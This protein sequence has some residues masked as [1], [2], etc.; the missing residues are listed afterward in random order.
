ML[1]TLRRFPAVAA[2]LALCLVVGPSASALCAHGGEAHEAAPTHEGGVAPCHE[3]METPAAPADDSHGDECASACCLRAVETPTLTP[4]PPVP[5]VV[6][7]LVAS[8][9]TDRPAPP[10]VGGVERATRPPP[11]RLYLE[12]G[13]IRV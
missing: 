5:A 13:R 2:I 12:T 6:A 7:V 3:G 10:V 9:E 4:A 8:L 1:R 11:L